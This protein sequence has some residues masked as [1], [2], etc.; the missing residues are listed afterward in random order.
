MLNV[1]LIFWLVKPFIE[2]F[3][4]IYKAMLSDKRCG[5]TARQIAT[6]V[7]PILT[8][9]LVNEQLNS[10]QYKTVHEAVQEMVDIVNK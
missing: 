10:Q 5:L 4:E 9:Q 7:L 6:K 3:A 1:K 2:I 8:P